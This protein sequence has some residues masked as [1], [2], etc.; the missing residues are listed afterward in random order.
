MSI[1]SAV[2][3]P[4]AVVIHTELHLRP[5]LEKY[6]KPRVEL[7]FISKNVSVSVR[8]CQVFCAFIYV[9]SLQSF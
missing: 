9:F 8:T 3:E 5:D 4:L 6:I 7:E 1:V 2:V